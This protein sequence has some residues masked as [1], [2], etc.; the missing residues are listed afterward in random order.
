MA[1]RQSDQRAG[2]DRGKLEAGIHSPRDI[3][4][5]LKVIAYAGSEC[6]TGIPCLSNSA[7]SP[8]AESIRIYGELTA[9]AVSTISC[10]AWAVMTRT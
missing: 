3:D 1:P 8:I 4:L 6:T 10:L 5:A 9:P 2:A 7:G